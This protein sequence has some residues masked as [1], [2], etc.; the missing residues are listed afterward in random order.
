MKQLTSNTHKREPIANKPRMRRVV[1]LLLSVLMCVILCGALVACAQARVNAL[2]GEALELH[3]FAALSVT[4]I[5]VHTG[6]HAADLALPSILTGYVAVEIEAPEETEEAEGETQE[7][8]RLDEV[9]VPVTWVCESYDSETPGTYI[10]VSQLMERFS[11]SEEMPTI[12]V[13]VVAAEDEPSTE[14]AD[15]TTP[16]PE[17]T[18]PALEEGFVTLDDAVLILPETEALV[19]E[20]YQ[21]SDFANEP[22]AIEVARGTAIE[23]IP[24]PAT[25]RAV[26]ALGEEIEVPVTW[27][28]IVDTSIAYEFDPNDYVSGSMYGYGPWVFTATVDA[29][30][31]Y[32]GEPVTASITLPDCMTV[33]SI[34]GYSSGNTIFHF[35]IFQGGSLKLPSKMTASMTDG[36]MKSVPVSWSGSYDASTVGEYQL[37][38]SVGGGYSSFSAKGIVSVIRNYALGEE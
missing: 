28:N 5:T 20:A 30:Y 7:T 21:I 36:G 22:I 17:E 1:L 2:D 31:T 25:L 15:E 16:A 12:S 29:A 37:R 35:V 10:F 34:G 8:V 11:Y 32:A 18:I 3:S 26:N 19:P 4:K 24:L 6:T 27:V 33:K 13:K 9:E 38:M 14:P 23:N